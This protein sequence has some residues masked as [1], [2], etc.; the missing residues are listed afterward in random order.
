MQNVLTSDVMARE[1]AATPALTHNQNA[2]S[3]S[4]KANQLFQQMFSNFLQNGN[5]GQSI[6]GSGEP[7]PN[8]AVPPN[9]STNS[10]TFTT[11]TFDFKPP[12]EL[13]GADAGDANVIDGSL[14]DQSGGATATD[15]PIGGLL[16]GL[17]DAST[18]ATADTAVPPVVTDPVD[19][20]DDL[21]DIDA[22][23]DETV[24]ADSA[25][26]AV[27]DS[28]EDLDAPATQDDGATSARSYADLINNGVD[29]AIS[30]LVNG[31]VDSVLDES[32][33]TNL[34]D[35][36]SAQ[37]SEADLAGLDAAA[38]EQLEDAVSNVVEDI[39]AD[40]VSS[41]INTAFSTAVADGLA[42]EFNAEY[43][44]LNGS[45]VATD[46][47]E[48]AD[49]ATAVDETVEDA[50][51]MIVGSEDFTEIAEDADTVAAVGEDVA[52]VAEEGDDLSDI[53]PAN[54]DS[55]LLAALIDDADTDATTATIAA[56][57]ATEDWTDTPAVTTEPEIALVDDAVDPE[58]VP[59]VAIDP[60]A[61]LDADAG[62]EGD[63]AD[64]IAADSDPVANVAEIDAD[65][66]IAPKLVEEALVASIDATNE[67][68]DDPIVEAAASGVAQPTGTP[69]ISSSDVASQ[70]ENTVNN[71]EQTG[72]SSAEVSYDHPDYGRMEARVALS[73]SGVELWFGVEDDAL[74]SALGD[75]EQAIE[76]GLSAQGFGLADFSVGNPDSTL[77]SALADQVNAVNAGAN[78]QTSEIDLT[79]NRAV[80]DSVLGSLGAST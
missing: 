49:I 11:V 33:M 35:A 25:T 68:G 76:D 69:E 75:I 45:D 24:A 50:A 62:A 6:A 46:A 23:A 12:M 27:T 78:P 57:D 64:A 80:Y 32:T 47:G 61:E 9:V 15:N 66:E 19:T 22:D 56:E 39:V 54:D 53:A 28:L 48:A 70:I 42:D 13:P 7:M 14:T 10:V 63:T 5:I 72:R 16:D 44:A 60:E 58:A 2:L 73:D 30:S 65:P 51:E 59:A 20:L 17:V 36:I 43:A 3:E 34:Q 18:G 40:S 38:I 21:S 41:A 8:W 1:S 77:E 26:P 29:D 79:L 4:D 74:R 31:A 52:D 37:V 55:E 67:A 71:L